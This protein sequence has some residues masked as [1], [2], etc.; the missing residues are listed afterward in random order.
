MSLTPSEAEIL[1]DNLCQWLGFCLPSAERAALRDHPPDTPRSFTDAVFLAEGLDPIT[2]DSDTYKQA[3]AMVT[4]AF[5]GIND[6][7]A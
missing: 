7:P 5:A 1:L 6:R 2:A 3:K 4:K